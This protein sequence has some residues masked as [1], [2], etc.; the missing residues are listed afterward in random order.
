VVGLYL[1]KSNDPSFGYIYTKR[2]QVR[3][4]VV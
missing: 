2:L 3:K 1:I 4:P